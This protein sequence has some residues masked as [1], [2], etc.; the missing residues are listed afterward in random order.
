[1]GGESGFTEKLSLDS[2]CLPSGPDRTNSQGTGAEADERGPAESR[3]S[4]ICSSPRGVV[5]PSTH[6]ALVPGLLGE[7][8]DSGAGSE[9][10]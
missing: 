10:V 3:M 7:I 1:M 6:K 5:Q 9:Y 4:S 2:R 8:H